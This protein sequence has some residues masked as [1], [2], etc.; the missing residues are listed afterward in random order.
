MASINLQ[1][2]TSGSISIS[3]PSIAGSNTL[4]LPATTQTLA[5]QNSLGVRNLIINGDMRIAQ[6]GTSVSGITTFGYLTV[7]RWKHDNDNAGI[8]TMEQDTDVPAGQGFSNSLKMTCTTAQASLPANARLQQSYRIEG[9]HLQH[10]KYGS[11][12]AESITLSFWVKTNKTGTYV[13]NLIDLDNSKNIGSQYTVSSANTWEKKTLTFSGNTSDNFDNDNNSSLV[14]EFWFGA[15]S[16]K[17]TGTPP[18]TWTAIDQ[19]TRAGGIT[20]NLADST[21]NYANITG[22]QL[23]VGTEATPFEHKPYDMEL[24]RCHRYFQRLPENVEYLTA[25]YFDGTSRYCTT[26]HFPVVMRTSTYTIVYGTAEYRNGST[27]T[28]GTYLNNSRRDNLITIRI[29][30]PSAPNSSGYALG[31]KLI[32]TWTLDAEL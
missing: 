5:T 4:T 19:T 23:E 28:N 8:W 16:D 32:G 31:F 7:D 1:G 20:V 2:D 9:Q 24:A 30:C 11:S 6:R 13:I 10:L 27:Y 26:V 21:S 12:N 22:V 25:F 15:G 18:T 17:T 14:I 29:T 3:A